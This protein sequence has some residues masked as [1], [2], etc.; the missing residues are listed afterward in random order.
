MA[1]DTQPDR[2]RVAHE[3]I[4]LAATDD[5]AAER[6]ATFIAKRSTL[7]ELQRLAYQAR[8]AAGAS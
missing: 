8:Q 4:E 5:E 3:I 7:R 6:V 2:L 1:H